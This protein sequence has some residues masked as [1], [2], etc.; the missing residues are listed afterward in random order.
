MA[1]WIGGLVNEWTDK[2]VD[3]WMHACMNEWM[4]A[5]VDEQWVHEWVVVRSRLLEDQ[6]LQWKV[7]THVRRIERDRSGVGGLGLAK[8][9]LSELLTPICWPLCSYLKG[10][11]VLT[12]NLGPKAQVLVFSSSRHP[13]TS[14]CR[15]ADEVWIPAVL[16]GSSSRLSGE[17]SPWPRSTDSEVYCRPWN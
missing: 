12:S 3:K 9:Y 5:W 2:W 15:R 13:H 7:H 4:H 14:A 11:Y 10:L 17:G 6:G 16:P 8:S 1:R